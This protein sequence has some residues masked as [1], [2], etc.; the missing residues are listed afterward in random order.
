MS[1]DLATCTVEELWRF[2]ASHLEKRGIG[3]VLV[4]GAVVSVHSG[5]AYESGDLDFVRDALIV[6]RDTLAEVMAEIGFLRR[7]RHYVHPQCQH[8]FVDFVSGPVG[9]GEDTRITPQQVENDGVILKLLSPTDCV[10]DRLAGLIHYG[11]R[12][13]MDQAILVARAHPV[14][15]NAIEAWAA[16]EGPGGR[17]AYSEL[18]RRAQA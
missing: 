4:G 17:D 18:R 16:G 5:G 13:H 6:R 15:W 8:L 2:V 7:Q 14:D 11:T 1:I 12:D 10:R 9:I 3:V